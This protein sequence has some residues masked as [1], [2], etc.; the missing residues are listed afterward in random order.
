M[1]GTSPSPTSVTP[2]IG[3]HG[4]CDAGGVAGAARRLLAH[5]DD[6]ERAQRLLDG[7]GTESGHNGDRARRQ[8]TDRRKHVVGERAS[9]ET[10]QD[11][12]QSGLHSLALTG[13]E[14]DNV[15]R[16]CHREKGDCGDGD[17]TPAAIGNWEAR[18]RW[19]AQRGMN[20]D[21]R[22]APARDG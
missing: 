8:R 20:A 21:G 18:P 16:E 9:R 11:L 13:S 7:F 5:E 2:S 14:Y 4:Q 6:V 10:V 15:E 1:S 19:R 22:H 17:D 12:G 3:R